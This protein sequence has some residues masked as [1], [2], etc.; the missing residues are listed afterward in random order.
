MK[1]VNWIKGTYMRIKKHVDFCAAHSIAGAGK[2]AKK[3]GH[4]WE[5]I[6]EID[7]HG[8][9]DHRGFIVD[10]ANV[11]QAAFKYDHDDLD[12]Y[13]ES[14]ST[15]NVAQRIADD[16]RQICIDSDSE[17]DYFIHVHLIE[18]KNNSA[19]AYTNFVRPQPGVYTQDQLLHDHSNPGG[20]NPRP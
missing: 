7:F 20:P 10:V 19:D 2:C 11:K 3:H 14:A 13:F 4:N 12:R 15:E 18:T 5:A 1:Q 6:I 16:V 8:E 9:L 17:G